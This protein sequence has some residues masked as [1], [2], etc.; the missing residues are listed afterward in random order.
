MKEEDRGKGGRV[1]WGYR[2]EPH[3]QRTVLEH[4]M[5]VLE[6]KKGAGTLKAMYKVLGLPRRQRAGGRVSLENVKA[7]AERA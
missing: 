6:P 7:A 4:Y 2:L 5:T 1:L 3:E